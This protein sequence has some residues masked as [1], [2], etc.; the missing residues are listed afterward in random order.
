MATVEQVELCCSEC[1]VTFWVTAA[2]EAKLVRKRQTFYCPNGHGQWFPG[3]TDAQR[4]KE[5]EA[6]LQREREAAAEERR[7]HHEERR[8]LEHLARGRQ[9]LIT[10][11]RRAKGGPL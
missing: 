2:H 7:L 5:A 4:A 10:K 6:A 11:L 3:K 9:S 1:K 8:R